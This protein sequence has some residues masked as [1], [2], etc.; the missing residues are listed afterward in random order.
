MS[1]FLHSFGGGPK[2]KFSGRFFHLVKA[3]FR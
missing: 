2:K 1:L 3:L